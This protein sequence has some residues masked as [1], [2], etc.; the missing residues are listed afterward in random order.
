MEPKDIV[1]A[2]TDSINLEYGLYWTH[3]NNYAYLSKGNIRD[4]LHICCYMSRGCPMLNICVL[5]NALF[6]FYIDQVTI[7]NPELLDKIKKHINNACNDYYKL[8]CL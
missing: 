5:P 8:E 1:K 7:N 6:G 2:I 3:V 4:L